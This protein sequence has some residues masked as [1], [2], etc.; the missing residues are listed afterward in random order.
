MDLASTFFIL[1]PNFMTGIYELVSDASPPFDHVNRLIML[2][3]QRFY[4]RFTTKLFKLLPPFQNKCL[5]L[6]TIL[7]EN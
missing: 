1:G 6:N 4:K 7:Y 3:L 5:D 2:D